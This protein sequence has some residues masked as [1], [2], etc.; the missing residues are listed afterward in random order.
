MSADF[1]EDGAIGGAKLTEFFDELLVAGRQV[2]G[3]TE[4]PTIDRIG[5]LLGGIPC[6]DRSYCKR[7]PL[8]GRRISGKQTKM[9][10]FELG[11]RQQLP[12]DLHVASDD[13]D[14]NVAV[15]E[16]PTSWEKTG[17]L[18]GC[19][20]RSELG[21][22]FFDSARSTGFRLVQN[23]V[24][25]SFSKFGVFIKHVRQVVRRPPD[26]TFAACHQKRNYHRTPPFA[27]SIGYP[28]IGAGVKS[29]QG[30]CGP[31]SLVGMDQE[32]S[33]HLLRQFVPKAEEVYQASV[34]SELCVEVHMGAG[35]SLRKQ[36]LQE[37]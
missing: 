6:L 17:S 18:F 15:V 7:L 36:K 13:E 19:Q 34:V 16:T 37:E 32:R 20:T 10:A 12:K 4:A 5:D 29:P 28:R 30:S 22:N 3:P 21:D 25:Y 8:L 9:L 27:K 14:R 23:A 31:D 26:V 33:Y 24:Q 2:T 11:I 35:D 1:L